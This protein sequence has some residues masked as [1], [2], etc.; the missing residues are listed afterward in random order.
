ML[1]P[2]S[3][4]MLKKN[5][6]KQYTLWPTVLKLAWPDTDEASLVLLSVKMSCYS[7]IKKKI[8]QGT[9]ISDFTSSKDGA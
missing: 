8:E 6:P 3:Q 7:V 1:Q 2:R 5:S 4:F 9:D